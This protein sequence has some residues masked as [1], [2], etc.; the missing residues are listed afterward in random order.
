LPEVSLKRKEFSF[1]CRILKSDSLG[2]EDEDKGYEEDGGDTRLGRLD[3]L[4]E[5]NDNENSRK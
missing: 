4:D 5:E 2:K 1:M 3:L